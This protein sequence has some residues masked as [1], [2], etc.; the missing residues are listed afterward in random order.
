MAGK[1]YVQVIDSDNESGISVPQGSYGI[2]LVI[3]D[4]KE[5]LR[6]MKQSSELMFVPKER[7]NELAKRWASTIGI[8]ARLK[9]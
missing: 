7:A 8:E 5:T 2:Q 1:A 3:G 4:Y 6:R 9:D